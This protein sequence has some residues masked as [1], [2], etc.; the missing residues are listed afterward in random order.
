MNRKSESI[1]VKAARF[2][3]NK[4]NAF[5]VIFTAAVI[6]CIYSIPK[7][8]INHDITSYLP[9]DTETRQ[10]LTI[11][12]EEFITYGSASIM[13]SHITYERAEELAEILRSVAGVDSVLFDDSAE[14][15]QNTSA[16]YTITFAAETESPL[17]VAAM[18]QLQAKLAGYD[19]YISSEVGLDISEILEQEMR[20]ILMIAALVIVLVLLFT[21]RSYLEIPVY[22]IVFIVSA[23]LNMGT[24]YWFGE[25]SFITNSI[26]VVL[27]LALA[28]DYA[29]I[30]CHR[31][32]EER[33]QYDAKEA[34]VQALSKAI[35][36]ISASSLTT[37]AGLVA[38]TLM[39]LRIGF[40]MGIVLTK[41]IICSL[42]TVF[43]LMP[44]LLLLFSKGIDKTRHRNFVPQIHIWGRLILKLRHILPIIFLL[45]I[46]SAVYLSGQCQYVFSMDAID[47]R[48]PS[49]QRVAQDKINETFGTDNP[50]AML[51]PTGNFEQEQQILKEAEDL[52]G[53]KMT[54]GLANV[55]IDD[56]YILTE[57][58]TPRRFAEMTGVE[59]EL[60]RLLYQAYGIS[61][62]EYGA[63]FQEVDEYSVPL[64][65]MFLFLYEQKEA[66]VIRLD[67]EMNENLDE[68]HETLI[69]ATN[70]LE[71]E[72]WSRLVFTAAEPVE[73]AEAF[74]LL[75]NLRALAADSYG[76]QVIMVGNTT[77]A[78]DLSD[79][80]Q[81]DNKKISIMTILFVIII[82]FFTFQSAG[83]PI[84]LV[85]TIQGS[86]WIN[87]SYPYL[88]GTNL[89]FL[90]YLIVSSIQMG[91]TIDYA[92]VITNR[93]LELKKSMP[94][95]T[96]VIEALN[97]SF[98]TVFT[99]GT[100]MTIAG[101]LIA[102]ISTDATISS[103]G[104]ALGR[105]TLTSIIL[106]M[107][108]LPQLLY[109]GDALIER[110]AF[111]LNKHKRSNITN[112]IVKLDGHVKGY[113]SGYIDAKLTGILSGSL[114]AVIESKEQ[115]KEENH[116][117]TE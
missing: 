21:S 104:F 40:D 93:F 78:K 71:G 54:L 65:R 89:F 34:A 91:A 112:D 1:M 73:S 81:G 61:Q 26:A 13:V 5:Y 46:G 45:I 87:F 98:A 16:L 74:Q 55:E 49:A 85:L 9:K 105:G 7:V 86:I 2:I 59:I 58:M 44:G 77:N 47:T 82:L 113:V 88:S 37:I 103:I 30:F 41:G 51:V 60:V 52:P 28:I 95:K 43:L 4:R 31:Y 102:E 25:I 84:L 62:E 66:G 79:S 27:Q 109:L 80:F 19:T 53:I 14:H 83:V 92:I 8:S 15:Y 115:P 116:N 12:E 22:M 42:I 96:A 97:Q 29:I 38:L 35:V 68:L 99:S 101:F 72:N 6:F 39:Q 36:E 63:I 56:E 117:E 111:T 114:D 90:A 76:D 100:I 10:G 106:V 75:E 24:N 70:Q 69:K 3:V 32:M 67:D 110:T 48:H 107:T 18:E 23:A 64:L 11:M 94:K 50:I 20:I 108:L 57:E 33:E 17:T